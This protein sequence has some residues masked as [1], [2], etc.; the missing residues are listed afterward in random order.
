[1]DEVRQ[2]E[3]EVRETIGTAFTRLQPLVEPCAQTSVEILCPFLFDYF[4]ARHPDHLPVA[5][6]TINQSSA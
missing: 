4:S 2:Q 3:E 1:M 6:Y 5:P